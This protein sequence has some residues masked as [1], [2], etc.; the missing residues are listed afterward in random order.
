[1]S[2]KKK[3]LKSKDVCKVTF[4]IPTDKAES[5]KKAH[6]VGS[7]NEWKPIP[8]DRLKDG[9][10]KLI[11]DLETNNEYPFRYLLDKKVWLTD[12]EADG[13]MQSEFMDAENGLVKV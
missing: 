4:R 11:K 8:M 10:F 6:L 7:F 3:F 5:H 1:M 2:L 13:V 9:S 12:V